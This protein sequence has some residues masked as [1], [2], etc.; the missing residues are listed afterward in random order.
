[1]NLFLLELL[2][3]IFPFL[4]YIF[5]YKVIITIMKDIKSVDSIRG[6]GFFHIIKSTYKGLRE[7]EKLTLL[8]PFRIGKSTDNDLVIKDSYISNYHIHFFSQ[9][10]EIWVEDLKSTNG[11]LINEKPLKEP[12]ILKDSDKID[13][14]GVVILEYKK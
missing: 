14:A 2:K 11:T 5:L 6:E 3:Y 9:N 4:I 12:Q 7:G 10:G 1:M 8:I 13:I